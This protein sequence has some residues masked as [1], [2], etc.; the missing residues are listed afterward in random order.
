MG[1]TAV[2]VNNKLPDGRQIRALEGTFNQRRMFT[3]HKSGLFVPA[4]ESIMSVREHDSSI[5]SGVY[6][7]VNVNN[8]WRTAEYGFYPKGFEK[9]LL[10]IG[11]KIVYIEDK[12]EYTLHVP[13]VPVK[14]NGENIGLR[15]AIG[16][17]IIPLERLKIEQVDEKNFT[18]SV[19]DD[20]NPANDVKVVDIMRPRGWAL[21]D[22]NGYPLKS[23]PSNDGVPDARCS[24]VRHTGE[25]DKKATGWHGSLARDVDVYYGRRD[26][27]ADSYW[28]VGSGVALVGREATSPL[29]EVPKEALAKVA[30]PK[31]LVQRAEQ[32][33]TAAKELTERLG[34]VLSQEAYARLIKPTLDEAIFL[35][36][37]AGKIESIQP[38]A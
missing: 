32:L 17:G 30:D 4:N 22:A 27:D 25:L 23:S 31:A 37:L 14:V 12:V 16:M 11:D 21:V 35:R 3:L 6:R 34:A 15:Q 5:Q 7:S 24:Y 13:D 18:V 19:T 33:E 10:P 9:Q 8:W 36:E 29:V 2:Q 28:S 26:V 1:A 38:K 20:F